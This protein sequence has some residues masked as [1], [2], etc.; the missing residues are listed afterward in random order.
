MPPDEYF[1]DRTVRVGPDGKPVG[2]P[3]RTEPYPDNSPRTFVAANGL[4]GLGAEFA[5]LNPDIAAA[6]ERAREAAREAER[7][8]SR[9][10]DAALDLLRLLFERM[11]LACLVLAPDGT[12]QEW[13]PQ[14]PKP[15]TRS[16]ALKP[17]ARDSTTRPSTRPGIGVPSGSGG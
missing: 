8:D 15:R 6:L 11:T 14:R 9:A 13:S 16:P 17:A 3:S 7:E 4:A 2:P 5:A 10:R 12:T 1:D